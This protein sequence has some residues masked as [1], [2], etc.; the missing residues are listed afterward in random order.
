[1]FKQGAKT[2]PVSSKSQS[3][4]PQVVSDVGQLDNIRIHAPSYL[5]FVDPTQSYLKMRVQMNVSRGEI[6]PDPLVGA[7]AF[8]RNL[9]LR[10]GSNTTTIESL[11]D[12]NARLASVRP[13]ERMT[14]IKHKEDLFEG[15]QDF[16]SRGNRQGLYYASGQ[17][18]GTD[19]TAP[20]RLPR[21]TNEI[22]VYLQPES[23]LLKSQA[24]LPI[25]SMGGL[26]MEIDTEDTLRACVSI[27]NSQSS[28]EPSAIPTQIANGSFSRTAGQSEFS[29]LTGITTNAN[30]FNNQF[31]IGD[32]VY[33]SDA[34]GSDE[35]LLGCVSGFSMD[36]NDK[37]RL[38]FTVQSAVGSSPVGKDYAIGSKIFYKIADRELSQTL[39]FFDGTNTIS[40]T[41]D[42]PSY[43]LSD[44][45]YLMMTTQPPSSF[46]E[47]QMKA[48]LSDSGVEFQFLTSEMYRFNQVNSQGITQI[49]IP[50][51][52]E[53]AKSIVVQPLLVS[54]YR[55]LSSS[56][57]KGV[58]D[59]A[60]NYQ[61]ILGSNLVPT[62]QVPLSRYSQAVGT[63]SQRKSEPLHMVETQ[64]AITNIGKRVINLQ[65]LG[66]HFVIAR[67]LN[68]YNQI[69]P[70]DESVSLRV[71]YGAGGS[72]KNFNSYVYKV[73][74][75][76]IA[77]GQVMIM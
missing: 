40:K 74:V 77:K 52:A 46:V 35:V 63:T 30:Q 9:I 45:E 51:Q 42:A 72:Q 6:V 1:M 22:E 28:E 33:L 7:H 13:F 67:G 75:M 31:S 21:E 65:S 53:R 15:V 8:I 14:D 59:D 3:V 76:V 56:S 57:F 23:G 38:H 47:S 4:K 2:V 27:S 41:F 10:D 20:Q 68:R 62:R 17:L 5:G 37:L 61:F 54:S 70:L 69:T 16:S 50:T 43:T 26:R 24:I 39:T 73:A 29:Y 64:K 25:A 36:G 49:Q 19:A 32:K 18:I 71:E 34:D 44:I 12:Y 48:S 11:E 66:D 60:L 58:P 55:S